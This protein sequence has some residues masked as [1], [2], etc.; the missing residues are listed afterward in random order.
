M[1]RVIYIVEQNVQVSSICIYDR[2]YFIGKSSGNPW[3]IIPLG[4]DGFKLLL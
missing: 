1:V 3:W 2:P 4:F